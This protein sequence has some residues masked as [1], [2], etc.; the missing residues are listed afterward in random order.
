MS[1]VV[2]RAPFFMA[3]PGFFGPLKKHPSPG[4]VQTIKDAT[5]Y[6]TLGYI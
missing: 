4:P 6:A 2:I 1:K 5:I 3:V